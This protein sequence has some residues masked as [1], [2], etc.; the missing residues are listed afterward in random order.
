MRSTLAP[1]QFVSRCENSGNALCSLERPEAAATH[2]LLGGR[3][4][5]SDASQDPETEDS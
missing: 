1:G 2:R 3:C 5:D 4:T